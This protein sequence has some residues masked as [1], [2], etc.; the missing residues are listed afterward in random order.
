L[1]KMSDDEMAVSDDCCFEPPKDLPEG[2]KKEM[3]KEAETSNWKK[4]KKGDEV[5]VHYVGTLESDGN[6]FDSSRRRDTPFVFTLGKGEVIK[7]WDFAIATMRKGELA[8]FTLQPEFA[9][10][11]AGSPPAVP[12]NATLVFE[13]ELISWISKDDL[14][15]DGMAIKAL[16]EEGSGW[17]NPKKGEEVRLSIRATGEAGLIEERKS[18]DYFLGSGELGALTKVADKVLAGM[19]KGERCSVKCAKDYI[20]PESAHGAVT[21][22]VHLEEIYETC[23]V[24][25]LKDKSVMKKQTKEGDGYEKPKD[26]YMVT[27]RVEDASDGTSSLPGFC[28]PKNLCFAS[29]NGDVCDALECAAAEMKKEERAVVTCS[30]PSK[31]CE[32]R[33]GLSQIQAEKV[34]FIVELVEF[35]KGRDQWSMSNEEKVGFAAARKDVGAKLFKNKR[36]ELALEKY[37]KVIEI[38]AHTDKFTEEQKRKAAEL[39][40]TSELNK[41]ACYLQ[42]G[43][44]TNALSVCNSILKD[45]RL[46]IKALFRRAKAHFERSE[47]VEAIQDLDRVL[48]LDPGNADAKALLPHVKRAQKLADKESKSTFAKMCQGFGKLNA[49]KE[50]KKPETKDPPPEEPVEERNLDLASVTFRID[51]RTQEGE[52]LCVFGATEALGAWDIDKAVPLVRQAAKRDLEAMM[53]GKPQP[54]CN[55]WEVCIDLPVAE[56]RVEYKY[57]VRGQD[58]EKLDEEGDKHVLQLA[59]MGGARCRC[60]DEWRKGPSVVED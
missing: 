30:V 29:G 10:G 16:L 3:V 19:N 47:H 6:E 37:K 9:Y 31:C 13:V 52:T 35:E 7:G 55:V 54:E 20:Y 38:L 49:G 23:D 60:A 39:K 41:A 50:N 21:L 4:P 45:D 24:S 26:G 17:K 12:A 5:T 27:L 2:V 8:K 48:G 11:E 53:A 22:E 18:L 51:R 56:G 46:N 59:G 32:V 33:L 36:F 28:G 34:V 25:L 58:G 15:G 40:R 1:P 44:P 57:A 14:F 42:L 43:D